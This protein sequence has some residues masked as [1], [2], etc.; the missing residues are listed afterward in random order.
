MI[1]LAQ[2]TFYLISLGCP[3][4]LVDSDSLACVLM[5]AGWSQ[6][7]GCEDADVIL[8]TTCSFIQ[9]AVEEAIEATLEAADLKEEGQRRLVIAGCL[10]ARY[11]KARLEKLLPEVDLFIGF[12]DYGGLPSLLDREQPLPESVGKRT[13][14][15]TLEKGY[16]YIKLAEGCDRRCSFCTIPVIRG[17]L[18]S[19]PWEAIRDEA[20]FFIARGARELVLVAQDTTSY[21]IDLY[22]KPSLPF[23]VDLLAELDGDYRLRIMYLHPE[24]IDDAV[25]AC[26][27]GPRVYPYLDIPFQHVDSSVLTNMGRRGGEDSYRAT[28]ATARSQL[29]EVYLRGTFMVGFPGEDEAAFRRLE[30]FIE[31]EC[32]DWLGLFRYS[33]EEETAASSLK[34]KV[35]S[36]EAEERLARLAGLQ[37][38][39]MRE[40]ARSLIGRRFQVL[41]EGRSLEAPGYW[42]ARSGREAP[43]VDG[44]IFVHDQEPLRPGAFFETIITG[45]EGIDLIGSLE[46][47]N[48]PERKGRGCR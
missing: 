3:K 4:N 2:R 11:G 40:K 44:T 1:A 16:V 43:E 13:L 46:I 5:S 19:R 8:I 18:V 24:G 38:E 41:V 39:I 6:V 26:M 20:A 37:E 47:Q 9:A 28:I 29:G 35:G 22:G 25:I 27:A 15:S 30:S 17:P 33:Q 45:S 48:L 31:A 21:G 7:H 34:N 32:F 42:E 36:R 14:A 12:E 10:V 23:L